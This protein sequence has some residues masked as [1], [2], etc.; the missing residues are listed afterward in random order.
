MLIKTMKK[1]RI[2]VNLNYIAVKL[3]GFA[4]DKTCN[5]L[6][7][8]LKKCIFAGFIIYKRR[9]FAPLTFVASRGIIYRAMLRCF[10]QM[11]ISPSL[12]KLLQDGRIRRLG[13]IGAAQARA[14]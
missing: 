4:T 8:F 12:L 9:S 14:L 3:R 11:P 13:D 1:Q 2:W 6:F 5:L 10:A 7:A